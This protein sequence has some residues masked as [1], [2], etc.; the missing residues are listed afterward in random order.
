MIYPLKEKVTSVLVILA[1][2][3]VRPD[4]FSIIILFWNSYLNTASSISGSPLKIVF[5]SISIDSAANGLNFV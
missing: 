1:G 3:T 4:I 2:E 5:T